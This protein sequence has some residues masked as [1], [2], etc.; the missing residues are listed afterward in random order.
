MKEKILK[1]LELSRNKP[2]TLT[3]IFAKTSCPKEL[4]Q[5]FLDCFE[6]LRGEKKVYCTN[7]SKG[8]YTLNPYHEGVLHVRKNKTCYATL[9][10]GKEVNIKD[11][12]GAL[13]LDKIL[14]KITDFNRCEGTIKEIV[15]RHGLIAELKTI[16]DKR[17]AVLKDKRYKIDI[18]KSIVDGTL[19][20]IKIDKTKAGKFYEAKLDRVIG[21]KNAPGIDEMKLYYEFNIPCSFNEDIEK[22]LKEIPNE[23]TEEDV[24]G[25]KDLRDK[26]IFT[27]D[28]D[29]TKD[30][31]DAVCVT[32]LPNGNYKL[33]VSIAD[34][35]HYV[36]LNSPIDLEARERGNSY[37]SPGVVNPM[38]PVKL[39]NGICSLNPNVDRLSLTVEME[40]D[41]NGSIID[42]DIYESVIR[43]RIQMTYKNVNKIL[44]DNEV[45]TGY[46]PYVEQLKNL[47]KLYYIL[48]NNR[49]KRGMV[50]FDR[51]EIK[52]IVD[53]NR[54]ITGIEKRVQNTGE[55]IIEYCML[56]ANECVGTYIYNMFIPF[57]YRVHDLPNEIRFKDTINLIKSY[58]E[59]IDGKINFKNGASY[60]KI[61]N[62]LKDSERYAIYC[63]LLLR[64]MAKA[65]YNTENYG[66][67]AIGIDNRK[68][69]GYA[70]FTSPI[71]RYSDVTIH[72][73]IKKVLHGE[74]EDLEKD[75][76]KELLT[77]I[78]LKCSERERVADQFE[79]AA[80]KMKT[81]EYLQDYIGYTYEGTITGFTN[82][83]MFVELD[84]LIE[85]RVALSSMKDYY[86]Y[87]E[88]LGILVGQNSK[89]IY[90]LGDKVEV[91][92]TRADKEEREIDFELVRKRK[93]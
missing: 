1:V 93:R 92:V 5:E 32:I 21:H 45:P 64:C 10:N 51:P 31:D 42:F 35:G 84:N 55:S 20:G 26:V 50:D 29:D 23:V 65:E 72:R 76:F 36:P 81:A 33:I 43:S 19:I 13:D 48:K 59:K 66:H 47:E 83:A 54:K 68:N 34:V 78:A 49:K 3:E 18:D 22:Q 7:S 41:Q 87:N 14:V 40:I 88:E 69:E 74:I 37:Y 46:E 24:V 2:M 16:D 44:N 52:I 67:F 27:I 4:E 56:L 62:S 70:H 77:K 9:D 39:A 85:G 80:N 28:G 91:V 53:D 63:Y 38:H 79:R 17:Y 30:I 6:E 71:R 8:I 15:E 12:M 61:L 75:D 57:I 82:S 11:P 89:K 90:R 86:T 58:G 25:R 60:Q 73:I